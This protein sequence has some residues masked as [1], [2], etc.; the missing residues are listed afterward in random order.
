[1]EALTQHHRQLEIWAEH[2]PDNF[3]N[4]AQLVNAEIARIE[5]RE[6]EAERLYEAAIQSARENQFVQNE[7]LAHELAARFY[8]SRGFE[9]LP[10]RTCG[11]PATATG[12]GAPREKSGSSRHSTPIS[13]RTIGVPIRRGPC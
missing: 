10:R 12:S 2:C 7:A 1:M 5:G 3:E 11:T 13:Q 8:A 4:R 9:K 6:L